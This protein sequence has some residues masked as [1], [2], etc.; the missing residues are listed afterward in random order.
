MEVSKLPDGALYIV[1]IHT[2]LVFRYILMAQTSKSLSLQ[3]FRMS[4][5]VY[6][7]FSCTNMQT[8]PFS[9][10]LY[11][12]YPLNYNHLKKF[13][14]A[15]NSSYDVQRDIE[16]VRRSDVIDLSVNLL[17][18]SILLYFDDKHLKRLI[19]LSDDVIYLD[20]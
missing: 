14:V 19:L 1:I 15:L 11:S 4:M 12:M 8:P 20:I 5:L 6:L 7:S 9:C 13:A 2:F 17:P 16:H 18:P 3:Y 10:V